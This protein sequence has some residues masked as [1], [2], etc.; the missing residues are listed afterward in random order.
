MAT[1]PSTTSCA[2]QVAYPR[3]SGRRL[4]GFPVCM[5][6]ESALEEL[7]LERPLFHSEADFQH[8]LAWAL[9]R[10]WPEYEVRLERRLPK[11]LGGPGY[12]LDLWAI[13]SSHTL[14]MELKYK[15][16]NLEYTLQEESYYLQNH[17]AQDIG[18]YD[19]IKDVSRL[20][21]VA[22]SRLNFS[23][24]AIF[25]TNDPLYWRLPRSDK[26]VDRDFRIHQGRRVSGRLA[27][28]EEASEGT[29]RGREGL[30]RLSGH[31]E[32][33]WHRYSTVESPQ[34]GEFRYLLVSINGR[35]NH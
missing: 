17:G 19:F 29:K 24:Y 16:R 22:S 23:G 35:D 6:I 25:L 2:I 26:T 1:I 9:H 34:Y 15:T 13:G 11:A 10:R 21:N 27:W 32:L 18:R 33:D 4:S 14:A 30:I 31:Y 7:A 8:A 20:E 5:N 12:A 28:S 3:R